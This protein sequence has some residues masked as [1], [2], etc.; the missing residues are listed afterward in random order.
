MA[1][2][3]L[4]LSIQTRVSTMPTSRASVS[5]PK[6]RG[7]G[8]LSWK[9]SVLP[10]KISLDAT[11]GLFFITRVGKSDSVKIGNFGW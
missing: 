8:S 2:M 3:P 6:Y 7:I 10:C 4:L 1:W 9:Q 11:A 5:A